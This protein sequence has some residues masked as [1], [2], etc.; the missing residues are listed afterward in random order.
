M[1]LIRVT[2]NK[3]KAKSILKMVETTEKMLLTIDV[4]E[5]PSNIIKEHYE[6]IRELISILMLLD[7]YKAY[8]EGAHRIQIE[9]L[10]KNYEISQYQIRLIDDLRILRNRIAYDGFF[11]EAEYVQ[12][13]TEEIKEIKD[14]LKALITTRLT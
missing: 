7:G 11:I 12:R 13:K 9:Y 4:N 10:E 6:I 8:G 2:P 1:D 14:N 5:F 3:E